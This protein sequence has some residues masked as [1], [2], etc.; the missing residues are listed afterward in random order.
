MGISHRCV[1]E[2]LKSTAIYGWVHINANNIVP[3]VVRLK[4]MGKLSRA[5]FIQAPIRPNLKVIT[6]FWKVCEIYLG[7]VKCV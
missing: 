1:Y 5:I 7:F 2:I 3:K 4:L 6:Q